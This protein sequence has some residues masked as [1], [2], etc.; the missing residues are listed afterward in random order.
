[1]E[2]SRL[3]DILQIIIVELQH[4]RGY[5]EGDSTRLSGLEVDSFESFQLFYRSGSAAYKIADIQ[6]HHFSA[7]QQ[8]GVADIYGCCDHTLHIHARLA[9][10]DVAVS[11]SSVGEPEAEW[12]ERFVGDIQIITAEFFEPFAI[13]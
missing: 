3:Y 1:M 11:E 9:Q 12:I 7:G 4:F 6:L 2:V 13:V 10:R 8:S 5:F